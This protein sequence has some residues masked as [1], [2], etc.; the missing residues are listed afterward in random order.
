L[1]FKQAEIS[2]WKDRCSEQQKENEKL[3]KYPDK[4]ATAAI[5]AAESVFSE[6]I[7]KLHAEAL[8][9]QDKLREKEDNSLN[10]NLK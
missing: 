2:Y 5:A 4:A 7:K 9:L 1:A 8:L 6:Q 10:F 3:W